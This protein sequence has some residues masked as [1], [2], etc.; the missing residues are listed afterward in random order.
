MA[1][2]HVGCS[3]QFFFLNV[4][5]IFEV[6]MTNLIM[7]NWKGCIKIVVSASTPPRQALSL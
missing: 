2:E 6:C 5:L 3:V 1:I 4:D 7:T